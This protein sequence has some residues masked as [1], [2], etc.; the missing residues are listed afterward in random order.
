MINQNLDLD[1]LP[2]VS[3]S[4]IGVHDYDDDE[5]YHFDFYTLIRQK[6]TSNQERL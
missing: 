5:L 4:S 6:S 1:P 3:D 2:I